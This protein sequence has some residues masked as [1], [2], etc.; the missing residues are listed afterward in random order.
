MQT[1]TPH[2]EGIREKAEHFARQSDSDDCRSRILMQPSE[3]RHGEGPGRLGTQQHY[4]GP[5]L[6]RDDRPAHRYSRI[7]VFATDGSNRDTTT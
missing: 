7:G 4:R 5:L 1:L 2:P 3:D 6:V